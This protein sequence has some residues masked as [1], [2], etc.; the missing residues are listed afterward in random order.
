[1][2]DKKLQVLV[3]S[4]D[5]SVALPQMREGNCVE[6]PSKLSMAGAADFPCVY[7]NADLP[8][9]AICNFLDEELLGH[10]VSLV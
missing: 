5:S 1:M 3:D 6:S 2:E 9:H 10:Q 7:Q 4:C 8:P